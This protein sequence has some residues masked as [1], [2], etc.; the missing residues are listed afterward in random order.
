MKSKKEILEEFGKEYLTANLTSHNPDEQH[1]ADICELA[2]RTT[3]LKGVEKALSDYGAHLIEQ[4]PDKFVINENVSD[5]EN[6]YNFG[7][8]RDAIKVSREALIKANK[9]V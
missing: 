2:Y 4:L 3:F 1:L 5:K 6:A 9:G 8:Y 7:I